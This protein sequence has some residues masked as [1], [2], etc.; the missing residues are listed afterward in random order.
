MEASKPSVMPTRSEEANGFELEVATA[1]TPSVPVVVILAAP[2]DV[3]PPLNDGSSGPMYTMTDVVSLAFVVTPATLPMLTWTPNALA[4]GALVSVAESASLPALRIVA[5]P[6]WAPTVPLVEALTN[7]RVT[8]IALTESPSALAIE[9]VVRVAVTVADPEPSWTLPPEPMYASVVPPI[10]VVGVTP[11]PVMPPKFRIL[12]HA[13]P[14]G[15]AV[16]VTVSEEALISA[17]SPM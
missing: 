7:C 10:D 11:S 13:M 2:T 3:P 17:L 4:V 16:A 15:V 12:D 5:S 14:S 1:L 8:P 6:T 9:K